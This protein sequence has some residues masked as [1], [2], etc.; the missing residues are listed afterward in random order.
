MGAFF[1]RKI[2]RISPSISAVKI[3][4]GRKIRPFEKSGEK[5]G[6]I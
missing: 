2:M 6:E 1:A 4:S 3:H 5:T